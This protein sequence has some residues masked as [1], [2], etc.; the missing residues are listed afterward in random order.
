MIAEGRDFL[1]N[2]PIPVLASGLALLWTGVAVSL[3]GDSLT[4]RPHGRGRPVAGSR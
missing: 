3:L 4:D 1:L 2:S